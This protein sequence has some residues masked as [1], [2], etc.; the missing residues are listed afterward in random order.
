VHDHELRRIGTLLAPV[1]L[2]VEAAVAIG[3]NDFSQQMLM[4]GFVFWFGS[5][6]GD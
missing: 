6:Y 5:G 3:E 1:L 4:G 2:R